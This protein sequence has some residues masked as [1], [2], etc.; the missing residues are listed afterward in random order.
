MTRA[1]P[2]PEEPAMHSIA[3]QRRTGHRLVQLGLVLFVLGLLVGFA[4]PFFANP[5]MGL[6]S[7][8]EGI[9][10]GMLL[11]LLGLLWPR[12]VLGARALQV[13]FVLAIYATFANWLATLLA[14]AWGAG[15]N[16]PIAAPQ[17]TATLIQENIVDFLLISLAI[18]LLV[19]CGLVLW[20][21]REFRDGAPSIVVAGAA[22]SDSVPATPFAEPRGS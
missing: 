6:T 11:M 19:A 10:N 3:L 22:A 2:F 5:R 12:L 14:A 9:M 13:T 4:V 18:T 17:P 20:G 15:R 8:L 16:M 1:T 21:L 7:H